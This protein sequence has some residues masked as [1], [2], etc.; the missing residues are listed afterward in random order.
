MLDTAVRVSNVLPTPRQQRAGERLKSACVM[1][2]GHRSSISTLRAYGCVAKTWLVRRPASDAV[3]IALDVKFDETTAGLG[4]TINAEQIA[5]G[6]LSCR[7]TELRQKLSCC[8]W[9][10]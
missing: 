6:P 3:I 7:N 4:S 8:T 1:R 2:D 10:I 9:W 5:R